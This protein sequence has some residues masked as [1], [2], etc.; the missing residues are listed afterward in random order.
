LTELNAAQEFFAELDVAGAPRELVALGGRLDVETLV[1]AYR[2]GCFP[3]PATGAHQ[4]SLEESALDLARSGEVPLLPGTEVLVPPMP[5]SSPEPRAVLFP[6]AVAIPRS[7]RQRLRCCGWQTT[8]DMAFEDVLAACADRDGTW[9][10]PTMQRAYTDLHNA[11]VAHSLEVWAGEELVGGLYGVLTGRVFSGESMFHH[12]SDA[13]KVAVLDLCQ[14]LHE[15]RVVV[16][17]TEQESEHLERLGQALI[18]REDYV[19][20]VH[21]FRDQTVE[22]PRE[23]RPVNRLV[24]HPPRPLATVG[25]SARRSCDG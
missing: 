6:D 5:W 18:A 21:R 22:L 17:D 24:P 2:S 9:I 7:L 1:A 16:I 23:R 10:T 19:S 15:V 8:V 11:G 12:V 20:L 3:W 25:V 13:S 4:Q 14:R